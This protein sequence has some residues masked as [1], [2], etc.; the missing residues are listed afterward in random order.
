[1]W[2]RP[3]ASEMRSALSDRSEAAEAKWSSGVRWSRA[4][5]RCRGR[6]APPRGTARFL[7]P[8]GRER[9]PRPESAHRNR[10]HAPPERS[11]LREAPG[12]RPPAPAPRTPSSVVGE[13]PVGELNH[14]RGEYGSLPRAHCPLPGEPVVPLGNR[15]T[16]RRLPVT[17][18]GPLP[19]PEPSG[20]SRHL[21][22]ITIEGSLAAV[23]KDRRCAEELP[24]LVRGR[25][26]PDWN[27]LAGDGNES[28]SIRQQIEVIPKH[29][30][31]PLPSKLR[32]RPPY[33][34]APCSM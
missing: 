4:G 18:R 3:R 24:D 27:G 6:R 23:V 20:Q 32:V 17:T 29:C 8:A 30:P 9:S 26:Y 12:R 25:G 33:S 22:L 2:P 15:N 34:N 7:R 11:A 5:V 16:Q 10:C 28:L 14:R 21:V 19:S 13:R 1:M 31:R